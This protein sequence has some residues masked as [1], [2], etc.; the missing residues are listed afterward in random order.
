MTRCQQVYSGPGGGAGG[1]AGGLPNGEITLLSCPGK[2]WHVVVPATPCSPSAPCLLPIQALCGGEE[3]AF[4]WKTTIL[5]VPSV[6]LTTEQGPL[7]PWAMVY[8]R[9]FT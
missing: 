7:V 5:L 9:K 1:A 8:H 6:L 3:R 4:S 2:P